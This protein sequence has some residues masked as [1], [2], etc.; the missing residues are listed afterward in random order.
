MT[1]EDAHMTEQPVRFTCVCGATYPLPHARPLGAV[2]C[3]GCGRSPLSPANFDAPRWR[4][5][6][7]RRELLPSAVL[8][9][10]LLL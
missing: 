1:A 9:R 4:E 5:R 3:P 6:W 7:H 2:T 8:R 10:H